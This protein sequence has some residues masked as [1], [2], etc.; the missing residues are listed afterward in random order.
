MITRTRIFFR[1]HFSCSAFLSAWKVFASEVY[2]MVIIIIMTIPFLLFF[3]FCK[4]GAE[5]GEKLSWDYFTSF[6][7]LLSDC[8]WYFLQENWF[9]LLFFYPKQF[10]FPIFLF[11]FTAPEDFHTNYGMAQ[12]SF[13]HKQFPRSLFQRRRRHR[14]F[15]FWR[16][17]ALK[18]AH[19]YIFIGNICGFGTHSHAHNQ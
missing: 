6:L 19:A 12:L 17:H 8:L 1:F 15:F 13:A 11:F 14:A 18:T 10:S 3:Y 9:P 2:G 16:Q 5:K 4:I 7:S